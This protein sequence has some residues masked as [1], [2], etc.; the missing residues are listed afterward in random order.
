M[1]LFITLDNKLGLIDS[2]IGFNE[3]MFFMFSFP[4]IA[5]SSLSPVWFNINGRMFYYK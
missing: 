2:V 3:G 5:I 4:F 1:V